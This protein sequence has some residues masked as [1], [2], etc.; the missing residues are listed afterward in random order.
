ML[1]GVENVGLQFAQ[2]HLQVDR[3]LINHCGQWGCEKVDAS[4]HSVEVLEAF[5]KLLLQARR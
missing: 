3:L 2:F 5:F 1:F 4:L